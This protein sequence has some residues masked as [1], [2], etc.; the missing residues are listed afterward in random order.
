LEKS[1][2]DISTELEFNVDEIGSQQFADHKPCDVIILYQNTLH[3]IEFSV[4]QL[5]K[6]I[7]Y[8]TTISM[9]GDVLKPILMI[10]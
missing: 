10:Q 4:L 7:S 5:E 2:K 1:L 8:M 6:R 9:A 3:M